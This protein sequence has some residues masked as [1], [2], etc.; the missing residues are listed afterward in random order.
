MLKNLIIYLK[1]RKQILA[2]IKYQ[3]EEVVYYKYLTKIEKNIVN[4]KQFEEIRLLVMKSPEK[5]QA[6]SSADKFM[7]FVKICVFITI[8]LCFLN[9]SELININWCFVFAPVILV[10]VIIMKALD[11]F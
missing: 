1:Y 6:M 8:G 4:Q 7:V 2:L 5:K 3:L 9:L 10:L 11:A